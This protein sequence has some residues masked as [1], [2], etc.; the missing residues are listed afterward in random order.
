VHRVLKKI[1]YY[2]FEGGA[3]KKIIAINYGADNAHDR[4]AVAVKFNI[5]VVGHVP[6]EIRK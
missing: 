4:Y 5:S 2:I 6:W 3:L 1:Q